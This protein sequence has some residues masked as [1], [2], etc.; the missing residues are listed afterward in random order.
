MTEKHKWECFL[1]ESYFHM[2]CVRHKKRRGFDDSIHVKTKEE[3]E[4]IRDKFNMC[5]ELVEALRRIERQ[6]AQLGE[7]F[8]I[9]EIANKALKATKEG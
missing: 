8:T 5:T 1:D 4:Y 2:F 6:S 7:E 9:N 3:A